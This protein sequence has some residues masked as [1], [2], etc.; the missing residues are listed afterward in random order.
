MRIDVVQ[1][2]RPSGGVLPPAEAA[3]RRT[4]SP[5]TRIEFRIPDSG[6]SSIA[7]AYEDALATPRVLEAARAAEADGADAVVINCTA[8]TGVA[9]AREA[10]SIPVVGVSEASFHLAAQLAHRFSVLTF[11][12]RIGARFRA[13]A[14]EWGMAGRLASVRSVEQPLEGLAEAGSLAGDLA[15]AA[16]IAIRTDGAQLLILGCTDFEL[17]GPALADRLR[18]AGLTVPLLRPFA[19]GLA[20]AETLVA[21]GVSHSKR[22]Y[23]TPPILERSDS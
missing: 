9:A 15:A 8:D 5:G 4:A 12:E 3:I 10:L 11:A 16:A 19:I 1:A 17:A 2:N 14:A 6:P 20:Q 23:P 7:S 22:A 13:M 18:D 21:L